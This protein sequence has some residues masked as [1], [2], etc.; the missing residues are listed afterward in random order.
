MRIGGIGMDIFF[1]VLAIVVVIWSLAVQARLKSLVNKYSKETVASGKTANECARQM[2]SM[3]GVTGVT[4]DYRPGSLTD[5][6]SPKEEKIYLSDTTYDKSSITAVAVAAHEC[7]HACQ[8]ADG[9]AAYQI[10]QL[11][12]PF[13]G[14]ASKISVWIAIGGVVLMYAAKSS[15]Y[16]VGYYISTFGIALYGM[17]FLFYLVT[18]PIERNASRRGLKYMKECGWVSD[19]QFKAAKKVLWAAGD[20]YAVALA[21]SAVTLMRLLLMRGG[22]RR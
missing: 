3:H 6:F 14:I 21:S 7:G 4:I 16:E 15:M 12:A 18:L 9:M 20:T 13:A 22:K 8:K 10:R 2:L 17:V 11:I 1:Y 19:S 5:C